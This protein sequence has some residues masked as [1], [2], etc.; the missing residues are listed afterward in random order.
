M[1]N[2]KLLLSNVLTKTKLILM[3]YHLFF[4]IL[5]AGLFFSSSAQH[6]DVFPNLTG[7]ELLNQLKIEYK[8]SAVLPYDDARDVMFG[9]V[10]RVGDSLECIYS[11]H[12][13]HL[14]F[15]PDPTTVAYANGSNDGIN[16]EHSYPQG[17][18]SG[19]NSP[20]SDMHHLF[21]TRSGVNN[22]RSNNP[23]A[24]INDNSTDTWYYRDVETETVPGSN[25]DLYAES[26]NNYFEPRESVK[27]DVARAMIYFYTM[28]RNEANAVSTTFFQSQ[29]AT[30]CDWHDN[31]PV[32]AKEL[33][34]TW[35]IAEYQEGKPNPFVL[36]CTLVYRTNYCS[37][38]PTPFCAQIASPVEDLDMIQEITISPNPASNHI[39]INISESVTGGETVGVQVFDISGKLLQTVTTKEKNLRMDISKFAKGMLLLKIQ[40]KEGVITKRIIRH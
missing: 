35:K 30:L 5:L 33:L 14:P 6:T 17:L 26:T 29:I 40:A 18:W 39:E 24:D 25:I 34:R 2:C 15:G 27:G 4:T 31:D 13:I 1:V 9:I 28:Y 22:D 8:P 11:G 7:N 19:G 20:K 12:R 10:D 21:P 16:T 37:G 36:D 38:E 32:D 23:Y 3:K